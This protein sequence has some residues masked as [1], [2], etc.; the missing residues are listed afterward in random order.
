MSVTIDNIIGEKAIDL[1][2]LSWGKEV[3]VVSMFSDSILYEF[4]EPWMIELESRN[5]RV[6]VGTYRRSELIEFVE[7]EIK[8]TQF[9]DNPENLEN[10][11]ISN[12]LLTYHVIAFDDFTQLEPYTP[13]YKKLKNG[14]FTYLTLKIKHTKNKIITDGQATT[15]AL[16]IR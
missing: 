8:L 2:Y 7:G 3:S 12:T 10:K 16:H 5:K 4:R 13:Q 15:V 11:R 6:T 14:K 1:D 9:D